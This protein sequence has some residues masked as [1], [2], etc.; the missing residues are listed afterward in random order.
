MQG[1]VPSVDIAVVHHRT[2]ERLRETLV[3]LATHKETSALPIAPAD[4][5]E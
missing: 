2:P 5:E 3:A 4:E 1:M